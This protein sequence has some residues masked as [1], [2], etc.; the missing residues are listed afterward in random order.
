V[1]FVPLSAWPVD[2]RGLGMQVLEGIEKGRGADEKA[3]LMG[4]LLPEAPGE[5]VCGPIAGYEHGVKAGSYEELIEA[6]YK[7]DVMEKDL[8][9]NAELRADW[10]RIKSQFE[11]DK[12]RNAK[13]IIRR[14]LVQERNFRPA[15]WRFA[16]ETE[17]QRF[18]NVFDA[19]C[20]KWN[21]YGIE[22][23]KAPGTNRATED[24]PLL[25]KLTVNVTPYGTVIM[26]PKYWSFDPR[27]DLKWK[28]IMRL[29]RVRSAQ[30]QGAKL[31]SNQAE[32]R[33]EAE[34]AGELWSAATKAGM[35]GERRKA[36]VMERLGWD[37]RTDES[38]LSRILKI[39]DKVKG[40]PPEGRNG[41]QRQRKPA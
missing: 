24:R 7:F 32:R 16:W 25:L 3:R 6:Q 30:K 2:V 10:E 31:S 34:R 11:V 15:D 29:H 26:V 28:E 22:G 14:R 8:E 41:R 27:R 35:K 37:T 38:R 36:W 1:G 13:G 17:A 40:M 39:R 33:E 18:Q 21:L 9:E 12:Y 4:E 23:R 20:H 19:F 5:E